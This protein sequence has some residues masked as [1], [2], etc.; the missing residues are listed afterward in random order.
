MLPPKE[1]QEKKEKEEKEKENQLSQ[2]VTQLTAKLQEME[3][4]KQ[5]QAEEKLEADEKERLLELE[6]KADLKALLKT[7]DATEKRDIEDLTNREMMDVLIDGVQEALNS[8]SAIIEDKV[9]K[10]MKQYGQAI[11]G[12]QK[13]VG[14]IQANISVDAAKEK[15]EDF[16]D[17]KAETFKVMQKYG[18]NIDPEDAYLI[19]KG[20]AISDVPGARETESERPI[21][22]PF[23]EVTRKQGAADSEG[24]KLTGKI[25][26]RAITD[27][28]LE[29][30]LSKRYGNG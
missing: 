13:A 29:T 6:A 4:E 24:K 21:N 1:I 23:G 26:F 14:Q 27:R 28:G 11:I 3:E 18:G 12:V 30:V 5:K 19:A 2:Q 22:T 7:S 8:Q 17:M 10:D 16:D 25:G 20:K 15:Y 9:S